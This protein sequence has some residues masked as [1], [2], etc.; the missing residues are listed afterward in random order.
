[1]V[2]AGTFIDVA[3][4]RASQLRIV[5]CAIY[6]ASEV[7]TQC[8]ADEDVRSKVLLAGHASHRHCRCKTV[9]RQLR[10]WPRIF[11]SHYTGHGPRNG[12]VF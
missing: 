5:V 6:L 11:M 8:A 4:P 7:P 2:F 12:R 10:E 3:P 9:C 1:M